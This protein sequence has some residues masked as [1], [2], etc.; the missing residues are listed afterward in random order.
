M[1]EEE[2]C[3]AR[4]ECA[5]S[6]SPDAG[7]HSA[8]RRTALREDRKPLGK[9][10]VYKGKDNISRFFIFFDKWCQSGNLSDEDCLTALCGAVRGDAR[11]HLFNSKVLRRGGSYEEV[12][13][14][15]LAAFGR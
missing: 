13:E 9:C 3:S 5:R 15:L 4:E 1:E 11:D 8:L 12:K 6:T 14:D 7:H 10:P 2:T